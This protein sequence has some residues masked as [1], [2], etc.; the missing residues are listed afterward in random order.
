MHPP[1][2]PE[3]AA[4]GAARGQIPPSHAAEHAA[5]R[6]AD[7][8]AA[9]RELR[10]RGVVGWGLARGDGELYPPPEPD[11]VHELIR[12]PPDVA[13]HR[14]HDQSGQVV[15]KP[16]TGCPDEGAVDSR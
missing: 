3:V 8:Q 4:G 9:R 14:R 1:V 2:Q 12:Q 6:D 16:R 11:V 10:D 5:G 13:R 7:H 15:R